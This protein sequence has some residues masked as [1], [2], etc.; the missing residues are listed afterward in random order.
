[1]KKQDD[2]VPKM[3]EPM[4]FQIQNVSDEKTRIYLVL[5]EKV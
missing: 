1:M 3:S 2:N 5:K 4:I